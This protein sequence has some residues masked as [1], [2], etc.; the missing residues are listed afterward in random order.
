M[1]W[2]IVPQT[3]AT[4][5][6]SPG[7][8]PAVVG[9]HDVLLSWNFRHLVNRRRRAKVNELNVSQGLPTIEIGRGEALVS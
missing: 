9:R 2:Q 4:G 8:F 7:P 1:M 3:A 5:A 6:A